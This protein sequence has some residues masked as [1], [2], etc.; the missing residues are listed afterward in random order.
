M[1]IENTLLSRRF[2]FLLFISPA[3]KFHDLTAKESAVSNA[4]LQD[5]P[6]TTYGRFAAVMIITDLE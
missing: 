5:P 1:K 2:S 3:E 4:S 6:V